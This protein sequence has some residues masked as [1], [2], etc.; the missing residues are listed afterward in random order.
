MGEGRLTGYRLV[1]SEGREDKNEDMKCKESRNSG[2]QFKLSA[3]QKSYEHS[4][5]QLL[6]M[7]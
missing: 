6:T 3:V 4:L 1:G 2:L 5:S 7:V